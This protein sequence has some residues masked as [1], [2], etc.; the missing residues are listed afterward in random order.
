VMLI[1]VQ[2]YYFVTNSLEQV[3]QGV[4]GQQECA[5]I[6]TILVHQTYLTH[7]QES[8][9]CSPQTNAVAG[10]HQNLHVRTHSIVVKALQAKILLL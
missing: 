10:N 5:Y 8:T 9:A 4:T 3:S 6:L 2:L 1:I 7:A